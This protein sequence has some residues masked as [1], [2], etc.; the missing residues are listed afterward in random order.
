MKKY[1]IVI[2]FI[3]VSL[4]LS[5]SSQEKPNCIFKKDVMIPMSDG[6][7]LAANITQPA[8]DGKWPVNLIE[9]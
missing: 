4:P 9:D 1:L 8:E 3:V 5:L 6:V 2:V 7:K